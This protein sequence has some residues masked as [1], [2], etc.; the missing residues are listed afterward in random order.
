MLVVN[1]HIVSKASSG[2]LSKDVYEF[3][4]YVIIGWMPSCSCREISLMPP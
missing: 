3:A 1:F 2:K 4:R